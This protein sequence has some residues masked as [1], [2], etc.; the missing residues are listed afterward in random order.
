MLTVNLKY[1][2]KQAR[3]RADKHGLDSDADVTTESWLD[4][5]LDLEAFVTKEGSVNG[6]SVNTVFKPNQKVWRMKNNKAI[7]G[8]I[9]AVD[10]KLYGS[11]P[12][13]NY[14][15][16]SVNVEGNL[17]KEELLFA[18]KEELINTL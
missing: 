5:L 2:I 7:S 13:I 10:I 9:Q 16:D 1:L 15:I 18:S 3:E 14:W 6:M 12:V 8:I 17:I 4:A 11:F